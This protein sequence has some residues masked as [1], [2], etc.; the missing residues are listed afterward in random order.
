MAVVWHW[1]VT[2][3]GWRCP[4]RRRSIVGADPSAK[5]PF[6]SLEMGRLHGPLRGQ[7]RSHGDKLP[8]DILDFFSETRT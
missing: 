2:G 5:A 4:Q 1:P 3:S 7:V 6:W 8:A